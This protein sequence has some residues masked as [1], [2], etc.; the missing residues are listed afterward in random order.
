MSTVLKE[1]INAISI[2]YLPTQEELDPNAKL[3]VGR[4]LVEPFSRTEMLGYQ[5]FFGVKRYLCGLDTE[6]IR[7]NVNF[8][9][10]E[11]K[12]KIGEIEDIIARLEMTFGKGTLDPTNEKHWSKI[13]LKLDRKTTNLDLTNPRTELL[14]HCIRAGGF[15]TVYPSI[16]EARKNGAQFYLVEPV[17]Y[18]ENK[19]SNK[20]IVNKAIAT[21]QKLYDSKS[22]DDMFYLAKY[23]LP[24]EKAYT[25]RT[26]KAILYDDLDKYINGELVRQSKVAS[27]RLFLEAARKTKPEQAIT[28]MVKDAVEWGFVYV[29]DK[30]EFKNNETGAVY[31]T[32]VERAIVHLQNPAYEHELE[33]VRTRVEQ[34]WSE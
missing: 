2:E 33:N 27:A 23:I 1:R 9:E 3:V 11:R 24:V 13:E 17:E 31:G 4:G 29:N 18:A 25:K 34:K 26:P 14:L 30:G 22:F 20:E 16:E 28:C 21:L 5:T 10:E 19:I 15:T 32:T 12:A 8:T 7:Y 6:V